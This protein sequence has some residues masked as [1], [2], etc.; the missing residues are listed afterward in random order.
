MSNPSGCDL[1]NKFKL[2]EV[3]D[4]CPNHNCRCQKEITFTPNQF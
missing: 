2:I 4:M 1:K 3:H